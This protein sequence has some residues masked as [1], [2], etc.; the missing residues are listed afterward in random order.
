MLLRAAPLAAPPSVTQML[1]PPRPGISPLGS[2]ARSARPQPTDDKEEL[3]EHSGL[4]VHAQDV[5]LLD[6]DIEMQV[7]EPTIATITPPRPVPVH[8]ALDTVSLGDPNDL[9]GDVSAWRATWSG[10][11]FRF[12]VPARIQETRRQI[13]HALGLLADE[14]DNALVSSNRPAQT[15]SLFAD[16]PEFVA[17]PYVSVPMDPL[18]VSV[19]SRDAKDI[20]GGYSP[21][22][23]D[24]YEEVPHGDL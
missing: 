13:V 23:F 9:P 11:K 6:R 15:H 14:T 18:I 3:S 17:K 24:V 10:D 22:G 12:R 20:L 2:S 8:P 5:G 19:A 21:G 1:A 16:V 4:Q 7:E